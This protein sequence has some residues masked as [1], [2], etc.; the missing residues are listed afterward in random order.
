MDH[1]PHAGLADQIDSVVRTEET[2]HFS[3][4]APDFGGKSPLAFERKAA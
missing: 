4:A 2:Q 1:P 3:R